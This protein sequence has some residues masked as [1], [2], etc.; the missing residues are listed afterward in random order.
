MDNSLSILYVGGQ[1]DGSTGLERRLAMENANHIVDVFDT[2]VYYKQGSRVLR[3][4]SRKLLWGPPISKLNRDLL[5]F[6]S[7]RRFDVIWVSK[8][9]WLRQHTLTQLKECGTPAILHYNTDDAFGLLGKREWRVFI[10]AIPFYDLHFVR[11]KENVNEY[12]ESGAKQVLQVR[13]NFSLYKHKPVKVS[14]I[15]RANYGGDVGFIGD[16]EYE[17]ACWLLFLA[18]NGVSIRV[19]GPNWNKFKL[20][21]PNLAIEGRG[22][23]GDSYTKAIC[24]FDINLAFLRKAN[25]DQSTSRSVEIPACG[26]FMLAERTEEHLK[27]FVEGKEADFFSTKEELLQKVGYYLDHPNMRNVIARA[28]CMRCLLSKL[29]NESFMNYSI[30]QGLKCKEIKYG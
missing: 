1:R 30:Q 3:Y 12:Y 4:L 11:R 23:Y 20:R 16:Y 25:R 15:D 14:S 5:R 24:S 28:G 19:W 13:P 6:T 17:R 26:G 21:H 27:M 2:D 8:G 29:D 18:N 22:L 10:S 9:I 7:G